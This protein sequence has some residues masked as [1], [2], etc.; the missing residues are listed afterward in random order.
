MTINVN[1]IPF[2]DLYQLRDIIESLKKLQINP[3]VSGLKDATLLL[4]NSEIKTLGGNQQ[5]SIVEA[6]TY[7]QCLKS[8]QILKEKFPEIDL[9]KN[10]CKKIMKIY[11]EKMVPKY[12]PENVIFSEEE[13][14]FMKDYLENKKDNSSSCFIMSLQ[15]DR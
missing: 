5:T 8:E 6:R 12:F 2:D 10:D 1:D 9:P 13:F 4:L 15:T 11:N 14:K 7:I 3:Q